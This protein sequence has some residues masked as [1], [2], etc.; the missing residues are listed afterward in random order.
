MRRRRPRA[1]IQTCTCAAQCV[2]LET[3]SRMASSPRRARTAP[4]GPA[5]QLGLAERS[6]RP[7]TRSRTPTGRPLS[8]AARSRRRPSAGTRKIRIRAAD[9]DTTPIPV[10]S[11]LRRPRLTRE[12]VRRAASDLAL[13]QSD[14]APTVEISRGTSGR[15]IFSAFSTSNTYST[16]PSESSPSDRARARRSN[17][18]HLCRSADQDLSHGL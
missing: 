16:K 3:A 12:S 7:R 9:G 11:T 17:R 2:G 10:T 5:Q 8:R 18:S 14:H 6:R 15:V 13:D 4:H 1:Q